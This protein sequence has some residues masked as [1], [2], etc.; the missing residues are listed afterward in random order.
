MD[1]VFN[2]FGNADYTK[3]WEQIEEIK[4]HLRAVSDNVNT[5]LVDNRLKE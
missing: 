3:K 5:I 1:C 4:S 2:S